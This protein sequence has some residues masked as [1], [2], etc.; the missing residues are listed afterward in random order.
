MTPSPFPAPFVS[1]GSRARIVKILLIIGA[2]MSLLSMIT[3]GLSIA[4]PFSG[5]E[6]P[7]ENPAGLAL[8][9]VALGVAVIATLVYITTVVF[10]LMW[11]HRS[12]K[13]VTALGGPALSNSP[14]FA[15]VSFFIP[16]VNLV[17][18]FKAVREIWQ[19]SVPPAQTYL[20]APSP[21]VW[22]IFW[23]IF[24]LL[25]NFAQNIAFRLS[26]RGGVSE[27]VV[28]ILSI[29]ADALSVIAA[30]F[31]IVVVGEI[32]EKQEARAKELQLGRYAV[33]PAPPAQV[34]SPYVP[35]TNEFGSQ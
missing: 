16:F 17:M 12:A 8:A 22:F 23:W 35:S 14:T 25:S 11:L 21:P 10:F 13:N 30:L 6:D 33:P 19:G 1:A 7:G 32:D 31:A 4:F 18:P 26:F 9:F 28:T 2:V 34:S 15:V 20:S 29:V 24:W 5:E 3:G 27:D